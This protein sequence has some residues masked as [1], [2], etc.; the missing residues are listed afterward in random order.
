M[1]NAQRKVTVHSRV[2]G[3]IYLPIGATLKRDGSAY[4]L[5]GLTCQFKMVSD[6]GATVVDW[7]TAT[8]VSAAAG[9]VQFTFSASHVA[10]AG[11]YWAWFRVGASPSWATFPVDPDGDEDA[12][13]LARLFKVVLTDAT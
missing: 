10:T 12:D 6:A 2:V 11:V 5:T 8:I 7:T 3:D 13:G 1:A 4:D 9:T